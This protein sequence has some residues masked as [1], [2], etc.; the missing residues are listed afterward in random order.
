MSLLLKG[1][2]M[3]KYLL[4]T[5][6]MSGLIASSSPSLAASTSPQASTI[7]PAG[8]DLKETLL[9]SNIDKSIQ[10]NLQK[11]LELLASEKGF[12]GQVL[13]S[14]DN[15]ILIRQGYGL[16][17]YEKKIKSTPTTTFSIGS[18]TKQ[19]TAAS[20]IQ[21]A[22]KGLLKFDDPI[23]K[24]LPTVP[25]G[26]QITI[27]QL[28]THTS[29]LY[30]FKPE[31]LP[32]F[33]HLDITNLSYED[34]IALIQNKPLSFKPGTR[35]EYSN[36]GYYLLS[37]L[38]EEVSGQSFEQYLSE[39]L[40]TPAGLLKTSPS[41]QL[42]QK[43]V[44]AKGYLGGPVPI[45]DKIDP[46]IL[47]IAAGAGFL[48]SNV[49]DL[50]RWNKALYSGQIIDMNH[51]AL[52]QGQSPEMK[53]IHSYGYGLEFAKDSYG[54]CY[55]HGGNT[56]GF[57]AYNGVY[58]QEN[59]QIIILTNKAYADL[60]S[61]KKDLVSI[62]QGKPVKMPEKD[63]IKL[64]ETELKKYLGT[65]EIK[66]LP[67]AEVVLKN[68]KLYIQIEN[69]LSLELK[70]ISE[71][72]FAASTMSGISIEFENTKDLTVVTLKAFGKEYTAK[73]IKSAYN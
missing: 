42:S 53:L 17:D 15:Q 25:H 59:T 60:A 67:S 61:I 55:F 33:S 70:V 2:F 46:I 51:L 49:D 35:Y 72:K 54:Q 30:N 21:L 37:K 5:I 22:E 40:F 63:L 8:I 44:E 58:P 71:N 73:K 34:L 13:I 57:T 41:Y 6:L 56:L 7:S 52:M 12:S 28:L 3:K 19:F 43:K 26:K 11:Y 36:T 29:G 50:Y 45:Q 23:S 32:Q 20:I 31:E 27:H 68:G 62:L 10:K 9:T 14:K 18:I 16:V 1:V 4:I 47:N 38:V 66:G 24:Y 48:S 64:T 69:M 39:H 65:Y